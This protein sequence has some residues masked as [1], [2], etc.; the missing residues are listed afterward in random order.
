MQQQACVARQQ[1]HATVSSAIDGRRRIARPNSN[2]TRRG[3]M[4]QRSSRMIECALDERRVIRER[5]RTQ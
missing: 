1:T 5:E 3:R 4:R 2:R